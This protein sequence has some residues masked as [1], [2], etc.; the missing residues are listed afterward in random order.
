VGLSGT[1]ASPAILPGC[2]LDRVL[3]FLARAW[4][5]DVVHALGRAPQLHFGALRR[6]L[7]GRVSARMLALRLRELEALGLVARTAGDTGRREVQY[8]L[9]AE[10]RMLDTAIARLGEALEATPLPASLAARS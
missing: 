1:D 5:A 6:A 9:T 2:P 10:G 7:P 4:T 3:G 8:R